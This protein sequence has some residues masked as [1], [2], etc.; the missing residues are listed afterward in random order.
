[1]FCELPQKKSAFYKEMRRVATKKPRLDI[2]K[3]NFKKDLKVGIYLYNSVYNLNCR[4]YVTNCSNVYPL[5]QLLKMT[6]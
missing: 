1:M 5:I 2:K 4:K 6:V 3:E